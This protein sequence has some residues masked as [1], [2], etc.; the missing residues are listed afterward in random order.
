MIVGPVS[1]WHCLL[2][3]SSLWCFVSQMMRTSL[4]STSIWWVAI[5]HAYFCKVFVLGCP[6]HCTDTPNDLKW[7]CCVSCVISRCYCI[8]TAVKWMWVCDTFGFAS[9]FLFKWEEAFYVN[10]NIIFVLLILLKDTPSILPLLIMR[11]NNL[12]I[13]VRT[14]VSIYKKTLLKNN[15]DYILQ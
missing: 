13:S 11:H 10:L 6:S 12:N 3:Y 15:F 7:L 1:A 9:F 8:Q 14:T 5:G 4:S 2:I